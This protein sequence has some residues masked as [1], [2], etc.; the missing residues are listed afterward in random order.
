MSIASQINKNKR[1]FEKSCLI[2]AFLSF[3]I[4]ILSIINLNS[5]PWTLG[6][7]GLVSILPFAFFVGLTLFCICYLLL[8]FYS[9]SIPVLLVS[10]VMVVIILFGTPAFIE[11]APRFGYVYRMGGVLD[12]VLRT[13]HTNSNWNS[14]GLLSMYQNWP[15]LF[16]L[17]ATIGQIAKINIVNI[18]LYTP[19][20]SQLLYIIPLYLI[21]STLFKDIKKTFI[22]CFIFFLMNWVNQDYFSSQNIGLFFCLL[23]FGILLTSM[24]YEDRTIERK[25]MIILVFTSLVTSHALS[26]IVAY[27]S[28]IIFIITI[29][30]M[31]KKYNTAD[32]VNIVLVL[33]FTVIIACWSFYGAQTTMLFE[34]FSRL[35][36]TNPVNIILHLEQ[37]Q[38][39]GSSTTPDL[40]TI[41]IMYLKMMGAFALFFIGILGFLVYFSSIG[42]NA[43]RMSHESIFC[44]SILFVNAALYVTPLYSS[45]AIIRVFLF[46]IISMTFFALQLLDTKRLWALLLIFIVLSVP[47]YLLLHYGKEEVDYYA[48]SSINGMDF[49]SYRVPIDANLMGLNTIDSLKNYEQ[50]NHIEISFTKDEN[51]MYDFEHYY[52]ASTQVFIVMSD[53]IKNYGERSLSDAYEA[54]LSNVSEKI[55]SN[56]DFK[57][58]AD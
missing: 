29:T 19:V 38:Q 26:S 31:N 55:Y 5:T 51:D 53:A 45:E 6:S 41:L 48:P 58:Y 7:F 2:G 52:A 50:F 44:I 3:D 49:V 15:A 40:A 47:A 33:A 16:D 28:I 56:G 9:R 24:R 22:A 39:L 35:I 12:Y 54:E 37:A 57:I 17:G 30:I 42:L 23:L 46:S 20:I 34:G 18:L 21:F 27:L 8:L 1:L 11:G 32:Y 25:F 14:V 4:I 36:Q 10:T 43:R 13:G